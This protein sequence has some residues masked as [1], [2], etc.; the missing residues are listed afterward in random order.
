MTIRTT[1][2]PDLGPLLPSTTSYESDDAIAD[3]VGDIVAGI[4]ALD[5]NAV[6]PRFQLGAPPQMPGPTSNWIALGTSSV[7]EA[8]MRGIVTHVGAGDGYDCV[9]TPE[10]H[11]LL[12][13]FY[14]PHGLSLARKLRDGLKVSPNRYAV[15]AAGL[16]YV[17]SGPIINL[18]EQINSSWYRRA[19]M[20]VRLDGIVIRDYPVLN[21]LSVQ[22]SFVAVRSRV[23]QAAE[24]ATENFKVEV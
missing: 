19:D 10:Q 21:L 13:S 7:R 18:G 8:S 14:G 23:G 4:L 5:R 17:G 2:S 6:R 22:G 20:T 1:A 15:R 12:L 11:E 9:Q 24:V 3:V 16:A